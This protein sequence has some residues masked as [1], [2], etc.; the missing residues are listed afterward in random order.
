MVKKQEN[1]VSFIKNY[2]FSSENHFLTPT[3]K[4][5]KKDLAFITRIKK[6]LDKLEKKYSIPVEK[7][8]AAMFT[9]KPRTKHIIP[10][11]FSAIY[12]LLVA[13]EPEPIAVPDPYPIVDWSAVRFKPALPNP[14]ECPVFSV[15]KDPDVY[16]EKASSWNSGKTYSIFTEK[17]PFGTLPGYG[18][19]HG[20]VCVPSTPVQ[21][22]VFCHET[23][24]WMIHATSSTN[25]GGRRTA[26][27]GTPGIRGREGGR[28]GKQPRN[29]R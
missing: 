5:F 28:R 22:Y 14:D 1:N 20:V 12:H 9:R 15:S 4:N 16:Q 2:F 21:G 10:K 17:H 11:E 27:G 18:T 7:R 13:P 19:T 3:T 26:P 8:K 29:H 25:L 6:T 24:K 23:R